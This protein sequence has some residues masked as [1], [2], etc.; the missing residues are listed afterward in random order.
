MHLPKALDL[1]A[2]RIAFLVGKGMVLPVHRDPLPGND[3]RGEPDGQPK[4]PRRKR[5]QDHR[6]VRD[7]T[8]QVNSGAVNGDLGDQGRNEQGDQKRHEH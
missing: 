2:V 7:R 8:M 4:H 6:T 1:R 5:V 3:S